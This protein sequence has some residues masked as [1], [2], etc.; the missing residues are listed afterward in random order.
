MYIIFLSP[1]LNLTKSL[2]LPLPKAETGST[3]CLLIPSLPAIQET[4]KKL[5]SGSN[6]SHYCTW[7]AFIL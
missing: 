1:S 3:L 7:L 4:R 5:Q 2:N 6:E